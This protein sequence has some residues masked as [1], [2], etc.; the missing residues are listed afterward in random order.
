MRFI[1]YYVINKKS[2]K[3]IYTHYNQSNCKNFLATL[4]NSEDFTIGYKWLSI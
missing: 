3:C 4:T 2:N 1:R